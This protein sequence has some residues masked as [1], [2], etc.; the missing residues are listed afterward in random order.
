MPANQALQLGLRSSSTYGLPFCNSNRY[1]FT[2][3]FTTE[4]EVELSHR[5]EVN[6][7]IHVRARAQFSTSRDVFAGRASMCPDCVGAARAYARS[8]RQH[9]FGDQVAWRRPVSRTPERT[10]DCR[11]HTQ[12]FAF[13]S[14]GKRL[15]Q[16]GSESRGSIANQRAC[17]R[18]LAGSLQVL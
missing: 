17:R 5:S 9:G 12:S 7:G 6:G 2:P 11:I 8:K 4:A 18:R 13:A 15:P 14:G 16:R 1:E 3:S 10:L